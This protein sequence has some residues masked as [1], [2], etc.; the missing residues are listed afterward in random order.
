MAD[1]DPVDIRYEQNK[2]HVPHYDQPGLYAA[3]S[4]MMYL[5]YGMF[6]GI[7][8]AMY[9]YTSK[10][11]AIEEAGETPIDVDPYAGFYADKTSE[12]NIENIEKDN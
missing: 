4:S 5:L 9:H 3:L 11:T 12:E 6:I 1:L 10:R 8:I 2:S 7:F